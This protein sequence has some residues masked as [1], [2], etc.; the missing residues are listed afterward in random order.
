MF[1]NISLGVKITGGFLIVAVITLVV[2]IIGWVGARNLGQNLEEIG[3]V[4]LPSIASLL[5]VKIG[6]ENLR[7]AQRTLL[8]PTLDPAA[9]ARQY[10]NIK[11]A[12]RMYGEAQ[13]VY[14]PLPQTQEEAEVWQ[15]YMLAVNVWKDVND[16]FFSATKKLAELDILN[17]TG[18]SRD[19]EQFRGD[20]YR[21]EALTSNLILLNESF[22]GGED[23]AQCAF[24]KWMA[25][26]ET[27]NPVLRESLAAIRIH[28]DRF[29]ECVGEI[30][31]H[32]A[33][34]QL[35]RA[36]AVFQ[37]NMV[38]AARETFAHF[39]RMLV[40]A[41]TAEGLYRSMNEQAMG[42]CVEKQR[43][44]LAL[45]DRIVVINE[46]VARQEQQA[47]RART[48]RTRTIAVFG[49][50]A[51]TLLAILIGVVLT[52]LITA[53]LFKGVAFAKRVADGD[54]TATIDLDQHD[55]I[56]QLA[57]ALKNMVAR[58]REIM[59]QVRNGADNVMSMSESVKTSAVTVAAT[60]QEMS[61]SSEELSQGAAE[62]AAA[63]E[64]A[65]SSME[66]MS[67]NISHNADNALQTEKLALQAAADAEEGGRSVAET[68]TAMKDI[69]SRISIIEEIARQT[70]LLALNA[71]IEA[72]RA[73][74]AGRG[75]SVVAAE[76][77]KLAERSQI[78]AAEI[79]ELSGN[80]VMIAEQAG[81]LLVRIVPDI[82]RTADLVQEISAAC[83]EQNAGA[84]QVKRAIQQ[85]DQVIQQNASAAEEMSSSS[86]N[87]SG[88]AEEMSA[89]AGEMT[90]QARALQEA[91]A[92]F[93]IRAKAAAQ[94]KPRAHA[95][96]QGQA[97][98][99]AIQH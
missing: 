17:P 57:R 82:R 64:E 4:R 50:V 52:R 2:G 40:E 5:K 94:Q 49:M 19:L 89:S 78:A 1:K 75:F 20:H 22:E 79:N 54:L 85:L 48:A 36:T 28:H 66:Q 61:S 98:V 6:L 34:G 62:Q 29:H 47:A 31:Q 87:M 14:E 96:S 69:A 91:I 53:P 32:M 42:T 60:S 73:G 97:Q 39:D 18:L 38:P 84:E 72:A 88:N 56:G 51:G 15:Q 90:E 8:S 92:F 95:T 43:A 63:A 21:L 30:K 10:E 3:A 86:E 80:S 76:V 68:V 25:S 16:E 45:L 71:A 12:R 67:S 58:L 55:E 37:E 35:K 9:R 70:N 11:N 65:S 23:P 24:G 83:N 13:A 44:V 99:H 27:A 77:R 93:R 33:A 74:D 41:D 59:L 81:Q 46:E 7:T 26:F